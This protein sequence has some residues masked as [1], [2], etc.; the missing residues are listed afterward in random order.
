MP[1]RP[2]LV[3]AL[4]LTAAP[5]LAQP[6]S[7]TADIKNAAGQTVGAVTAT[8]APKGVILR[9]EAKGLAPGWHGVHLHEKGDCSKSDFTT[10]GGHIH[11]D[12]AAAHGLLNPKANDMGDLPNI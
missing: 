5:A 9:V 10:A 11:S 12:G 2:L 8:A 1:V 7:V 6:A 3:A 4:A